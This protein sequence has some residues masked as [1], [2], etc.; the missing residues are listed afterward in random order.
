MG[1]DNQAVI[2]HMSGRA[3]QCRRLA[4]SINDERARMTLLQM[5]EEIE[6]DMRALASGGNAGN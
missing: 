1:S 2:D 3:A 5:A 6:A 4:K